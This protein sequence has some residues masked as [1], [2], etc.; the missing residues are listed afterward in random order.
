R[1]IPMVQA[2][3]LLHGVIVP[4]SA[5]ISPGDQPRRP[6][7]D[8]EQRVGLAL[9][10]MGRRVYPASMSPA[11]MRWAD[12]YVSGLGP[13]DPWA[14]DRRST[15]VVARARAHGVTSARSSQRG[16]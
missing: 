15:G 10:A 13:R 3:V 5:R 12:V 14:Q 2:T 4:I 6:V 11:S 9:D 8:D 1:D 7:G 16:Y